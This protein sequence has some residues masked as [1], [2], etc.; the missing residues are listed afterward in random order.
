MFD[1]AFKKIRSNTEKAIAN[2]LLTQTMG[3]VAA[4]LLVTASFIGISILAGTVWIN[5]WVQLV[6]CFVLLGGMFVCAYNKSP[7][8]AMAFFLLFAAAEGFFLAPLLE[9][10]FAV[11][12]GGLIVLLS[13][14]IV[15]LIFGGVFCYLTYKAEEVK[16]PHALLTGLSLGLLGLGILA[17]C[18]GLDSLI[19][20]YACLGVGLFTLYLIADI[21]KTL[22][23]S[24]KGWSKPEVDIESTLA[25]TNIYL[26]LLNLFLFF[27]EIFAVASK[28]SAKSSGFNTKRLGD[29]L[30]LGVMPFLIVGAILYYY[31]GSDDK[32]LE[33]NEELLSREEK[34]GSKAF[35]NNNGAG[36]FPVPDGERDS[37]ADFKSHKENEYYKGQG[38]RIGSSG[39]V[40]T[41]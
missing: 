4:S 40:A 19:F 18:T 7:K 22:Y 35:D 26:D 14:S 2:G 36:Y 21:G 25:A 38:Y 23:T 34:A 10:F 33:E 24:T 20:L 17:I 41:N 37:G 31:L 15:A 6:V 3:K 28:D 9:V 8:G 1:D 32:K 27:I 13:A 39:P 29:F 12:G 5:P 11:P 30:L 16:L